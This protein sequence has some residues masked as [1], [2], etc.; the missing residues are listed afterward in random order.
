MN[1]NLT[2]IGQ[3]ITFAIF[4]WFCMRFI[5]PPLVGALE[6]RRQQ[7]EDGLAAA[8]RGKHELELAAKGATDKLREAKVHAAEIIAQAQE[9]AA[10]II[11]EAKEAAKAEGARQLAATR[12]EMEQEV[13]RAR[14]H[15]RAEVT[16]LVL[17]CTEKVLH[18]EVDAKV[19]A[20]LLEAAKSEL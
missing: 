6:T 14:E 3:T 4:V 15:L 1:I 5:W 2:L 20:D 16:Q 8:D 19:H 18:R 9:Q 7:I 11:D 10:H 12:T 17:A 13:L